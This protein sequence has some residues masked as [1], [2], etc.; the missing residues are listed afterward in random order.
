MSSLHSH[1]SPAARG[2]R[3]ERFRAIAVPLLAALVLAARANAQFADPRPWLA[4]GPVNAMVLSGNTLYIGGR[5]TSVGPV[6]FGLL[7]IDV[8]S[9]Q[10]RAGWPRVDG[11][12]RAAA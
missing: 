1:S 9:T 5:F 2:A 7:A 10:I 4:N 12:V 3:A 11:L 6:T 8:T